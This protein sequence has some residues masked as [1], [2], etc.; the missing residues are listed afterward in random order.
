MATCGHASIPA[1]HVS[2][3]MAQNAY[4]QPMYGVTSPL[5][6]E[7]PAMGYVAPPRSYGS[8]MLSYG[9][10]AAVSHDTPCVS[11]TSIGIMSSSS[12]YSCASSRRTV[13]LYSDGSSAHVV[14]HRGGQPYYYPTTSQS[15]G[16]GTH[17]TAPKR[18]SHLFFTTTGRRPRACCPACDAQVTC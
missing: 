4:A 16:R 3:A 5:P 14:Y 15:S 8:H 11:P 2:H 13:V 12:F 10:P 9:T 7:P 1:T 6:A 18:M 17:A